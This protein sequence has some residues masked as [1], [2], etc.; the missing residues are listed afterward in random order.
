MKFRVPQKL[1]IFSLAQELFSFQESSRFWSV[2]TGAL[3]RK[4]VLCILIIKLFIMNYIISVG[5]H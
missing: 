5:G 3:G 1:E 2:N 4:D